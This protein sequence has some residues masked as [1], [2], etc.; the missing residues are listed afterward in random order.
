MSW[1]RQ[2]Y[3]TPDDRKQAARDEW[4]SKFS[5]GEC[6]NA[7]DRDYLAERVESIPSGDTEKWLRLKAWLAAKQEQHFISWMESVQDEEDYQKS[8][9]LA[10]SRE[11]R[12]MLA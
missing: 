5:I 4:E 7:E 10:R 11:D 8:E 9:S 1:S 6:L 3:A 2:K 12:W